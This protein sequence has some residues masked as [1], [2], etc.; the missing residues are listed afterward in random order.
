MAACEVTGMDDGFVSKDVILLVDNDA[1]SRA[2]MQ[3]ALHGAG[4]A[5]FLFTNRQSCRETL[6]HDSF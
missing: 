2:S 1:Q 6:Y 3:T 5:V 4:Y